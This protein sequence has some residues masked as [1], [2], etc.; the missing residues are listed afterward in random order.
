MNRVAQL[1]WA[2]GLIEGE[3]SIHVRSTGAVVL[4][5]VMTDVDVLQRLQRT[6]GK[7]SIVGPYQHKGQ[8]H[9]KPQWH[10][11]VTCARDVA[12]I[13]M[14]LYPLTHERRQGQIRMMLS[15]W[16]VMTGHPNGRVY[17]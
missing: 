16:R 12:A 6:F 15:A 5:V 9:Y 7:G 4:T 11:T 1:A 10:W 8:A 13:G 2:A 17:C 14:T 3:G